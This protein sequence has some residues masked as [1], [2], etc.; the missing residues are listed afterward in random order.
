M[1]GTCENFNCSFT[2]PLCTEEKK[3]KDWVTGYYD[4]KQKLEPV[5]LEVDVTYGLIFGE[6][7]YFKLCAFPRQGSS[8]NGF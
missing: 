6:N 7:L 2:N 8:L 5:N 4:R 1:T 3:L